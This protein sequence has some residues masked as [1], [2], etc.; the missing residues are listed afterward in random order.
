MTSLKTKNNWDETME[1]VNNALR[2]DTD[3][4]ADSMNPPLPPSEGVRIYQ[5]IIHNFER[6][7]DMLTGDKAEEYGDPQSMCRRIG[8]RWFGAETAEVDVALMM[9]E[10]KIERI[11]YDRSKED[12]YMDAIAYLAMALAFMQEGKKC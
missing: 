11:K 1:N 10:L 7:E 6:V 12:S 9:A 8:Q 4:L 3:T 2:N 5:R